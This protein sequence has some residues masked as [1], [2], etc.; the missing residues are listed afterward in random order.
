MI[1]LSVLFWIG[2]LIVVAMVVVR[3][4]ADY[5]TNAESGSLR[6]RIPP[7]W[8]YPYIIAKN[9]F[10]AIF[11]A[12]GLAM[13]VL[14]GQGILTLVLGIGLISFPGKHRLI[15]R[16]LGQRRILAILNRWRARAHRPPLEKPPQSA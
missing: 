1:A 3:L 8:R 4:P 2:T 14:P 5:L 12:A 9:I 11:I 16:V 15:Q 10:G 13:L 6:D 7:A